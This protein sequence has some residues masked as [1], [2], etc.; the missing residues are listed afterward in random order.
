LTVPQAE[1][2]VRRSFLLPLLLIGSVV[3]V[4]S[5]AVAITIGPADLSVAD[6]YRI[7][8]EHMGFGSSGVSRIKDA[9]AAA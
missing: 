5:I 7:T 3:L 2:S 9:I 6:V 1:P 4:L 8:F